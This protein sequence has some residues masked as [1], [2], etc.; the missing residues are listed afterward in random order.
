MTPIVISESTD[1]PI[2]L[3]EV[4]ENVRAYANA[5][6]ATGYTEGALLQRLITTA[7]RACE[8]ELEMSLVAKT[9]EIA[10]ESFCPEPIELPFGPVRS[11]VSVRYVNPDG[12]DTAWGTDQYRL[13][14]YVSPPVLLPAYDVDWPDARR[15]VGSIR[16]RYTAG[17]PSDDSPAD[18]VPEPIVQAMH[19]YV[20]HYFDN[21]DAVIADSMMELPLGVRHLLGFYRQGLGV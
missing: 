16:V 14:A 21:R 3:E 9:L 7:R 18:E 6:D 12:V 17:Y 10:R 8:Q 13:N 1:E 15:D 19:L 20:K 5:A 4:A 2:T 11:I